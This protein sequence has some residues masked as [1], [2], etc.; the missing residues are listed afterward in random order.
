MI[1]IITISAPTNQSSV[2][3]GD[4]YYIQ[5]EVHNVEV[6]QNFLKQLLFSL[7]YK[8]YKLYEVSLLSHFSPERG[9]GRH[10][11]G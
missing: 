5:N 8:K 2:I 6:F 11:S 7:Y 4:H 10:D 9:N 3:L 1:M